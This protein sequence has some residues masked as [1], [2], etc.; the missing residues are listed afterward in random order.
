MHL[1]VFVEEGKVSRGDLGI[2]DGVVTGCIATLVDIGGDACVTELIADLD[3]A[4]VITE[5]E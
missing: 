1:T 5:V 2:A 3:V 4:P